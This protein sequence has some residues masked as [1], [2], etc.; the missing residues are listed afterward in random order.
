M[1]REPGPA[2]LWLAGLMVSIMRWLEMLAFGLYALS[3]TGSPLLVA[4][5][6]LCRMTPLL[7]ASPLLLALAERGD[8]RLALVRAFAAMS[9][10]FGA[11]LVLELSRGAGIGAVLLAS[12]AGGL[13]WAIEF[14][15]RRTMLAE[16]GGLGRVGASMGLEIFA[17]QVTRVLGA[18]LGGAGVAWLGLAGVFATG[19]LLYGLGAAVILRIPAR[20]PRSAISAAVHPLARLREGMR[21][22]RRNGLLLATIAISAAFNLF[23]FPYVALAPVIAERRHGL[24]AAG[25]GLLLACEPLAATLAALLF[26]R[27]LPD[28]LFRLSYALGPLLFVSG[29]ALFALAG[30]LGAAAA[31]LALAGLGMAGFTI[32]QM[33]LPLRAAP[34]EL[35]AQV[36][37]L[38][39]SSIGVAPLG[40]LQAGLLAEAYGAFLAQ[41]VI[42]CGGIFAF[43]LVLLRWPELRQLRPPEG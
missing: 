23:A 4:L 29:T 37:G 27:L 31:A 10:V 33:V 20:S 22:V 43:L 28:R 9:L 40:L 19:L 34:P 14:P 17:N 12:L 21:A 26:A 16:L 3:A 2:R 8:R 18:V 5:T 41:L 1:I 6:V 32:G 30:S 35:R 38:V 15:L 24:T 39:T 25:T 7:L 36:V 11:L 13:F 42:S